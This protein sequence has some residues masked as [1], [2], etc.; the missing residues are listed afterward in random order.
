MSS[1]GTIEDSP[2]VTN[3]DVRNAT[4]DSAD[5]TYVHLLQTENAEKQR[6]TKAGKAIEKENNR[7][8]V[9]LKLRELGIR[10]SRLAFKDETSNLPMSYSSPARR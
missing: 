7:S 10:N 6:I 2:K 4:I 1:E 9:N 8:A 3:V 5:L